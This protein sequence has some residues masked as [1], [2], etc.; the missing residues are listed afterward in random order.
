MVVTQPVVFRLGD[1]L[2]AAA[3]LVHAH[4]A[5]GAKQAAD[6]IHLAVERIECMRAGIDRSQSSL[7]MPPMS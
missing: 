7:L 4:D 3:Q 6:R 1:R 5:L 2:D